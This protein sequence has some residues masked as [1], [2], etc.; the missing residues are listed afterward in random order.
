MVQRFGEDNPQ[1]KLT[2]EDVEYCRRVYI[3]R[4]KEFGGSALARRFGVSQQVISKVLL[5]QT[6][7]EYNA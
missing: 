2:L 6:W 5:N 1:S 7:R 3:P 4:D